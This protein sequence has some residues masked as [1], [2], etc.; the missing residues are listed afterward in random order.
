MRCCCIQ[1]VRLIGTSSLS[2]RVEIYH[3]NQWGTVCDDN[4]DTNEAQVCVYVLYF[5]SFA[6]KQLA[7]DSFICSKLNKNKH[8]ILTIVILIYR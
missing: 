5:F 4:F 6:Q 3:N 1:A 8:A 7:K 2:G